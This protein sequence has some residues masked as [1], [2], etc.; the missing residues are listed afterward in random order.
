MIVHAL[1]VDDDETH[2]AVVKDALVREGFR[3][4]CAGT[5]EEALAA[6]DKRLPDLLLLDWKLPDRDGIDVCRILR[7][8]PQTAQLPIIML[9][10]LKALDKKV[11][12]LDTGADDYLA[13]PFELQELRARIRA[14]LRRRTPWL[15]QAVP[16]EL[17]TL[18]LEPF[19]YKA[20][21]SDK[22][23]RLTKVEFEIL[24][25]LIVHAGNIVQR[26]YI[27]SRALD[28]D[29]PTDSRPLDPHFSRLREKLGPKLAA[30]IET[31]RGQGYLFTTPV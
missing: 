16:I 26:R 15:L 21:V 20:F 8:D 1:I 17:G 6:I 10:S 7:K 3:V 13:K 27:E 2:A 9:T 14:V 4:R 12:G 18:R 24:Y 29:E 22:D 31:A 23:I 30:C 5:V 28:V 19:A 25:L 11:E